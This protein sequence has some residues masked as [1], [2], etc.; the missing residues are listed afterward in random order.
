MLQEA[1]TRYPVDPSSFPYYATAAE[2]L[3]HLD[4]ARHAL[5]DYGAL[6]GDEAQS[7]SRTMRIAALSLR[8]NDPA[9]AVRWLQKAVDANPADAQVLASL[10][11]AQARAGDDDAARRQSSEDWPSSPKTPRC[12]V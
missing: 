6:A 10:G 3:N 2:Q 5:I 12:F 7:P 8:L 11:D 4:A 1:T 9:S